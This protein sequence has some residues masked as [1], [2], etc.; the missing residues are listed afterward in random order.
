MSRPTPTHDLK[1][2]RRTLV[3]LAIGFGLVGLD[4]WMIAPLFPHMMK[5]LG[6]GY[7]QLGSLIGILSIA[8]GVFSIV[9]GRLSD[10]IGRRKIMIAAMVMF[11][12]LSSFSG[13]ATGFA[14]LLLIRALMGIAEGAF[15]PTSVAA[16]GEASHPSRRGRNQGLQLS[17]FALMGLGLAPIIATQ[18]LRVVPSWHWVFAVSA[19]PGLIVALLI[20]TLLRDAPRAAPAAGAQA[21]ASPR[22]S[23]LFGSRN[24]LLAMLATFCAMAGIFVI[25]AMVPNYLVDYLHLDTSQMGFVVSAIGFGGFLGEFGLAS[26][27]DYAG[28]RLTSVLAFTGAA[29]SLYVFARIGANPWTLFIVLFV[30]S[31]FAL[32]MLGVLTGPIATEAAPAGLVASAIGITSGAGEIFGGGVAPAI[33]GY[34]AQHNGIQFT[35]QFALGGLICGI[36]VSMFLIETAPRV[37]ARRSAV[38]ALQSD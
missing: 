34:I 27:S 22:W 10:R 19:V 38:G 7:Q 35:L 18:L 30:V 8:W 11:S 5:D 13:F 37:V 12:L 2:E 6:L 25:G 17:M 21:S 31:F 3:L 9:M 32:G 26:L 28:R 36:F 14:S 4:R 20:A 1:N 24:V 23:E 15:T 33:A 16:V 29:L